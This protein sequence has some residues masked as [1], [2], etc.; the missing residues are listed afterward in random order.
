MTT[1]NRKSGTDSTPGQTG[2]VPHTFGK[3]P[4]RRS[5]LTRHPPTR[6]DASERDNLANAHATAP[7]M[8][9]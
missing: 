5:I 1:T 7:G 8:P 9:E 6:A 4:V 3:S 2:L